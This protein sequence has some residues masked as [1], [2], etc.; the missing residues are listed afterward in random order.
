MRVER[1]VGSTPTTPTCSDEDK[2]VNQQQQ[3]QGQGQGQGQT[4]EQRLILRS[5]NGNSNGYSDGG[6]GGIGSNGNS[7]GSNYAT[8]T[9][10]PSSSS[11]SS[12]KTNSY[13]YDDNTALFSNENDGITQAFPFLTL[14]EAMTALH[15]TCPRALVTQ[16]NQ[17]QGQAL[18]QEDQGQAQPQKS[19]L[20]T[21]KSTSTTPTT[22][23]TIHPPLDF[24]DSTAGSPLVN[25]S[26]APVLLVNDLPSIRQFARA[27]EPPVID[28]LIYT[29]PLL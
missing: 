17:G 24:D 6:V 3:N 14:S 2:G 9:T 23:T 16:E 10:A 5:N 11:S 12:F 19:T 7:D 4:D 26:G 25:D 21:T 13:P 29:L 15:D 22:T 20:S 27:G 8:K 18:T 28:V 1:G